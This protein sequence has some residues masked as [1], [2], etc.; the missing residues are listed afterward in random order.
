MEEENNLLQVKVE[1]LLD[2]VRTVMGGCLAFPVA[3]GSSP[4]QFIQLVPSECPF[5]QEHCFES[6]VTKANQAQSLPSS[7]HRPGAVDNKH[8]ARAS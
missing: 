8:N 2:M 3:G 4:S 5:A 1:V 7:T 6:K